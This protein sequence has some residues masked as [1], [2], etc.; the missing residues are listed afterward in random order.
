MVLG[1]GKQA[2]PCLRGERRKPSLF[3]VAVD[4]PVHVLRGGQE[5]LELGPGVEA[6]H[7]G[8]KQGEGVQT[9]GGQDLVNPKQVQQVVVRKGDL[10]GRAGWDSEGVGVGGQG[11][12]GGLQLR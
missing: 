3:P 12:R 8:R 1:K 5:G 10:Q 9:A 6:G 2:A 11:A 4:G 7:V